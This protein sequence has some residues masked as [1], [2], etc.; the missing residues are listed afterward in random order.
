MYP[1]GVHLTGVYLMGVYL[2]GVYLMGVYLMG[3]HLTGV[4]LIGVQ[5][6]ACEVHTWICKMHVYEVYAAVGAHLGDTR[7]GN[8]RLQGLACL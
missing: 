4:H 1:I 2:M 5:I 8:A 6:Y 7:L 3:M